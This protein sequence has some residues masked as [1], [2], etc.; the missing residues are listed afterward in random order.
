MAA[1]DVAWLRD[2]IARAL[3]WDADLAEGIA[4]DIASEGECPDHA[5][6]DAKGLSSRLCTRG[7]SPLA[8]GL[9]RCPICALPP[10]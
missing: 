2:G 9:N 8:N 10:P 6:T 7:T 1:K 5:C 4:E 3:G